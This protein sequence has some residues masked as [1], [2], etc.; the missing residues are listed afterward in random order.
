MGRTGVRPSS[1]GQTT[2]SSRVSNPSS[3]LQTPERRL[4]TATTPTVRK[5]TPVGSESHRRSSPMTTGRINSKASESGNKSSDAALKRLQKNYSKLADQPGSEAKL[6]TVAKRMLAES[7]Q[8]RSGRTTDSVRGSSISG[9]NNVRNSTP[10]VGTS[11]IVRTRTLSA[12]RS[13]GNSARSESRDKRSILGASPCSLYRSTISFT[14]LR[15][16]SNG[17]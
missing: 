9:K 12:S 13:A 2:T 16:D 5:G 10:N 6:S 11:P 17:V 1:V 4:Q 7:P 8:R 15:V 14:R 3:R